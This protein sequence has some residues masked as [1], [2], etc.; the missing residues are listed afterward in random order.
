M[1]EVAPLRYDVIFKKAFCD[2]AVFTALVK[3]FLDITLDIDKVESEKTFIPPIGSV[4]T[5]F[6]LFAEDKKNRI[7]VEVQHRHYADTYERFL[8]YQC[9]AMVETVKS[10]NDYRFPVTVITLV[11]LTGK[12]TPCIDNNVL[13]HDFEVRSLTGEVVENIYEHK[14]LLFFP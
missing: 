6:D 13:V 5:R 3:D 7:I 4:D 10:S 8:Y 1:K 12:K 2:K 11:F 14:H 9:T